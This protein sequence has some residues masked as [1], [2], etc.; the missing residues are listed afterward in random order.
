VILSDGTRV[1]LNTATALDL[2]FDTHTRL[3]HLRAGEIMVITAATQGLQPVDPRPLEVQTAQG[4]IRALGTRFSVRQ[5][6]KHT[7]VAVQESAVQLHPIHSD[8]VQVLLA[9]QRTGF[10]RTHIDPLRPLNEADLAW[11]RGQIIADDMPLGAF[12]AEL[13]RYRPGV[14]RCDPQVAALRLSGVFPVHD[15][16]RILATLPNVLPVRVS[17]RSRYWV[18]IEKAG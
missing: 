9:G 18:L 4:R 7:Q 8:R 5:D 3:L 10:S 6:D 2:H 13:D 12:I 15:S 11:T 14:L 17:T 1:T 16:E